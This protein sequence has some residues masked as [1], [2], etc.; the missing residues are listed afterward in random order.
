MVQKEWVYHNNFI[1]GFL[2]VLNSDSN[3]TVNSTEEDLFIQWGLSLSH[4]VD[5][6]YSTSVAISILSVEGSK[7]LKR[8]FV[9]NTG[10]YAWNDSVPSDRAFI[11][12]ITP[13]STDRIEN[14]RIDQLNVSVHSEPGEVYKTEQ[15]SVGSYVSIAIC[16]TFILINAIWRIYMLIKSNEFGENEQRDQV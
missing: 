16:T 1:N 12:E 2:Q 14:F 5:D 4:V 6:G 15:I 3:G 13:T 9:R 11:L 8:T 10:F 7:L